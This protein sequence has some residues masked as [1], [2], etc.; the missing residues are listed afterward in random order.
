MWHTWAVENQ[1]LGLEFGD[2]QVKS[3]HSSAF[4]YIFLVCLFP[5]S[6]QLLFLIFIISFKPSAEFHLLCEQMTLLLTLQQKQ[7]V[8]ESNSPRVPTFVPI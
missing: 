4:V 5:L 1:V 6:L 7:K 2:I 8:S 3:M